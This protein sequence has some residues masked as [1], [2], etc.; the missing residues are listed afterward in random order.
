MKK[1]NLPQYEFLIMFVSLMRKKGYLTIDVENLEYDLLSFK[2]N[3]KYSDIFQNI[4]LCI[5]SEGCYK[6]DLKEGLN[7]GFTDIFVS[8]VPFLSDKNIRLILMNEKIADKLISIY[9]LKI[10]DKFN[11]LVD[12]YLESKLENNKKY[13]IQFHDLEKFKIG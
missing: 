1:Y 8:N 2:L 6:L 10:Y 4:N 5:D 9:N 13:I 11:S 3:K 7:S 12:E